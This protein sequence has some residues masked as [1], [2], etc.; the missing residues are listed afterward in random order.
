[1]HFNELPI[2][3]DGHKWIVAKAVRAAL[4]IAQAGWKKSVNV[5]VLALLHC[6]VP[7]DA[8]GIVLIIQVQL[9]DAQPE[10]GEVHSCWG[11]V[12]LWTSTMVPSLFIDMERFCPP[13]PYGSR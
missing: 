3:V 8:N 11:P 6:F 12:D 5:S 10:V 9:S 2:I 13:L 4:L 1:M 7:T